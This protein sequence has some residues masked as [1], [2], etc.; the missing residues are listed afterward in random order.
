LPPAATTAALTSL[1]T[2]AGTSTSSRAE[3]GP[4]VVENGIGAL[5]WLGALASA[6]PI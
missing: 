4:V 1:N 3:P 2:A 6:L 5:P